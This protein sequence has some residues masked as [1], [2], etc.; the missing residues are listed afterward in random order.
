MNHVD[1]TDLLFDRTRYPFLYT[2]WRSSQKTRCRS[3]HPLEASTFCWHARCDPSQSVYHTLTSLYCALTS[4]PWT[5]PTFPIMSL[6]VLWA[7]ARRCWM[8]RKEHCSLSLANNV[9]RGTSLYRNRLRYI[10]PK[11]SKAAHSTAFQANNPQNTKG[12]RAPERY[13]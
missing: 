3:S 9:L 11:T 5:S 12:L 4:I 7:G 8:G 6:F 1:C 13:A 10:Q 2:H